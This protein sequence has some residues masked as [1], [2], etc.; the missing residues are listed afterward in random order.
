MKARRSM[1]RLIAAGGLAA[2]ACS[3]DITPP[4]VRNLDRPSAIAF[5]C[6]GD[7][8]ITDP[9]SDREGDVVVSAQPVGSCVSRLRGEVPE[10]QENIEGEPPLVS[11]RSYAFVLQSAKGTVGVIE[12]ETQVVIDSD[13]LTP[14]KNSIPIGTLP[15]GLAADASGCYMMAA[16]AGSCD[17]GVLDVTSALKL[18]EAA[19]IAR[20]PISNAAG[21]LMRARPRTM[22]AGPQ[23]EQIG[24]ECPASGG[25]VRP[26][27]ALFIAYPSCNLVAVVDAATGT[28]TSGIKFDEDGA[29]IITDGNVSCPQECGDGSIVPP[30]ATSR[31]LL[32]G[33]DAG[34]DAGPDAAPSPDAGPATTDDGLPRPVALDLGPDGRLYIGSENSPLVTTVTLDEAGLPSATAQARVEGEVGVTALAASDIVQ[35]GGELGTLGGSAG[36]FQYVYAVATDRTIRVIDLERQVECDAQVDPRYIHDIRDPGFLSCMAVGDPTTP[37]RRPGAR[38]PGIH[39]PRDAVP[40]DVTFSL[41]SPANPVGDVAP[42][43]MVG[44]Y[45]FVTTSDGFTYVINVDDDNYPDFEDEDD[46]TRANLVLAV[47]H[48]VRDFVGA[49]SDVAANC[50]PPTPDDAAFKLGPRLLSPPSLLV[51]EDRV[52]NE[53]LHLMPNLRQVMCT[54]GDDEAAVS[55][56]DFTAPVDVRERTFPDWRAIFNEQVTITWEGGLSRDDALTDLDGPPVRNGL[57]E[58]LETRVR[59]RD[60]NSPFCQIGAEPFDVINLLG[61]DPSFGDAQCGIGEVCYIHPDAP[62]V[63]P[64]G[65]CMPAGKTDE[66][67]GLC[68]DFL[69]TRRQYVAR[70]VYSGEVTLGNRRRV[71]RTSPI[72]GCTSDQQCQDMAA[73]EGTLADPRHPI[74]LP[75]TAP[76][77]DYQWTCAADP[78]RAPAPDRCLMSCQVSED[79][80]PGLA[81]HQGFCIEGVI[82]PPEC[83]STVQRYTVRGSDAFIV[84]GDRSGYLHNKIVDPDTGECVADPDANPLLVGRIPL[85]A[86]PC[87]GDGFDAV[88]PNPCSTTVEQA[89]VFAGY[90]VEG[91]RCVADAEVLRERET[92]AIR[93]TN[94]AVRLHLVDVTTTGDA[95]CIGDR[96]G[97][98]PAFSPVYP[99]FQL[100]FEVVGGFFPM[101][102][103]QMEASYPIVI[104]PGPD[105][106]IWVLDEGDSSISTFGRVFTFIPEAASDSFAL[107]QIL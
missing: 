76:A 28:I 8:R 42:T 16:N 49:R 4:P 6:Y 17:L 74:D 20:I 45:A 1:R 79:C 40:L 23:V 51:S 7:M 30:E 50:Q 62:T 47:P 22:V 92:S 98:L 95:E 69:I 77:S 52:A 9:D 99:G 93:F 36:N 37:P 18:G 89:E 15:V 41:V 87:T 46:P 64:T 29:A 70:S 25:D 39:I 21:E 13:P 83:V 33:I 61:C 90:D 58:Q 75:D 57:V 97:A 94:P 32:G 24:L 27:G 102:V 106:R 82:P 34:P 12:T 35:Q 73:Y 85:T 48:Q 60:P 54:A 53:K 88:S 84:V 81:C 66:L 101:F 26:R 72:A 11:P 19:R 104:Q 71:L 68:R 96:G 38:S 43:G 14:G 86:P 100:L 78:T 44:T 103:P 80:E 10:G 55:E 67:S 3:Q 107:I 65:V 63:V 2:V 31:P 5:A 105:G 59:L 56:L 91:Q